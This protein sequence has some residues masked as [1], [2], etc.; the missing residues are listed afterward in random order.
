MQPSKIHVLITGAAGM[1][2]SAFA[3]HLSEKGYIVR[4]LD[5]TALDVTNRD[6]TLKEQDWKPDWIIHTA[7]IVNVDF[8]ED[9]HDACVKNHIGGTGNIIAL[10]KETGAKLFY[11]QSF[12]I[13]DG[14]E[15]PITEE[16]AP[17]PLSIYGEAK[18][19]AEQIV[20]KELSDALVVRMG[21]F[22]GGYQ[23]DKNFVG[24][25]ARILKKS[26]EEKKSILQVSNRIWQPTYI[27]DI[28]E[29]CTLLL[30]KE[31]TGVYHMASHGKASFF[32]VAKAMV[33]LLNINNN[34]VVTEI[35]ASEYRETAKRPLCVLLENKRLQDEGLDRMRPW[36]KALEEYLSQE[37]F[38]KLF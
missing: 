3:D 9:N 36:R 4:A 26:I 38:K 15:N 12:L 6:A 5:H 23:K 24:T 31:K 18:W 21:G 32:Q 33:E 28:A 35:P 10:A 1:L 19:E 29:N 7:G 27:K 14:K 13:F 8:C 16:A 34:I 2:G 22:F 17:H 20:R 25:F 30:E 11:P 37:Y